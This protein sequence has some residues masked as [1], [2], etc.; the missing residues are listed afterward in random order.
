MRNDQTFPTQLRDAR[1]PE[2][3]RA[4]HGAG[5]ATWMSDLPA[6]PTQ[7]NGGFCPDPPR[8]RGSLAAV[9]GAMEP[10]IDLLT[11]VALP[12]SSAENVGAASK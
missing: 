6:A 3:V 10:P 5:H 9:F 7:K 4:K 2:P 12:V 8:W 11:V 1:E